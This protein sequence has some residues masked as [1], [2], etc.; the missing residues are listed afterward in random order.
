MGIK[1]LNEGGNYILTLK[2][3]LRLTLEDKNG[4]INSLADMES[5]GCSHKVL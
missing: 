3:I 1:Q 2:I 4:T 5:L